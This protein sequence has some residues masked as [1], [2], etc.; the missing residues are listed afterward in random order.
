M[1]TKTSSSAA[2]TRK[3]APKPR[4]TR[5]VCPTC[6]FRAAHAMGLGRHRS[7]RHG[8]LSQ[9]QRTL[10]SL[11]AGRA[12]PDVRPLLKRVAALEAKYE[13]LISAL[14]KAIKSQR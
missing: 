13:R 9:R 1:P 8:V 10:R 11:G 2:R 7:A 6:G 12:A 3:S 5:F 4:T 14:G